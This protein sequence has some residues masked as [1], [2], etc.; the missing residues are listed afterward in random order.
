MTHQ[1]LFIF[2]IVLLLAN[3]RPGMAAIQLGSTFG[4]HMVLP[5]GVPVP[6]WGTGCPGGETVR[7]SFDGQNLNGKCD[8]AGRWMVILAPMKA[9]GPFQLL[10]QIGG[11]GPL[12]LSSAANSRGGV[13]LNDVVVGEVRV[14][15]PQ[16]GLVLGSAKNGKSDAA[17]MPSAWIR[18][19]KA[20][21]RMTDESGNLDRG[22]WTVALPGAPGNY[23]GASYS[24]ARELYEKLKVPVGVIESSTQP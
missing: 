12:I 7:L 22:R 17:G 13:E 2:T 19:Y 18:V 3:A 20:P 5:Q 11:Y 21:A 8:W 1:R 10:M 15:L 24:Y 6:I 16:S 14:M 4:E 9:G 23:S